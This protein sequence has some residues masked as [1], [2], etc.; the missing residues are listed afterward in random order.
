MPATLRQI[1]EKLGVSVNTVSAILNKGRGSL[2]RPDT[3]QAVL[4]AARE[5][6][7][8]PNASARATRTGKFGCVAMLQ[9]VDPVRSALLPGCLEAVQQVLGE[10][11]LHLTFAAF[12][13]EELLRGERLPQILNEWSADGL[14]VNYNKQVP[15]KLE[16]TIREGGLPAVW[17]NT[18]MKSD[19]VHPDDL[20]GG[21][22]AAEYLLKLGHRNIGFANY[23]IGSRDNLEDLH[24]SV[25]D[26]YAGYAAAM[27]EAGCEPRWIWE[28]KPPRAE[29]R[30]TFT[31]R[32]LQA[33]HRPTAVI[34]YH[35]FT[36]LPI[37][38]AAMTAGLHVPRDL[39][40]V[41]FHN[42]VVPEF[43]LRPT[44]VLLPERETGRLAVEMLL[45]KI[46]GRAAIQPPRAVAMR[47]E[48]GD[49]CAETRP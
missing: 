48:R 4:N 32:W 20:A 36:A 7:Y 47:L 44:T 26:R 8:R 29:D 33:S 21:R 17:I 14:L 19:C 25:R 10:R 6:N 46:D 22:L 15:P 37:L 41:V 38:H 28:E 35:P 39:S 23:W 2:Y 31:R 42:D 40:L 12:D 16:D 3:R 27:R 9:S 43:D 49:T 24:Y 30:V 11:R 1:A 18:R 34:A 13:D 45:A 5:L